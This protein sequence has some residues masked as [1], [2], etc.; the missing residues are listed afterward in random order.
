MARFF[1]IHIQMDPYLIL[2]LKKTFGGEAVKISKSSELGIFV[3]GM[4][5]D[6]P[7]PERH[8]RER[9]THQITLQINKTYA[10]TSAFGMWLGKEGEDHFKRKMRLCFLEDLRSYVRKQNLRTNITEK[11]AIENFLSHYD[12]TEDVMALESV[13]RDYMRW[14]KRTRIEAP[15]DVNEC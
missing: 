14:K 4:L 5:Q 6:R 1:E 13:Y 11:K 15:K 10:R 2:Y 3:L 12:I 8:H 7:N 9:G